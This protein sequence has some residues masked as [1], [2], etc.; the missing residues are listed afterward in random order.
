MAY[1]HVAHDCIV[2]DNCILANCVQLGGHVEIDDWVIIGGGT[3]FIN[4]K[5]LVNM[6]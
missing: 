5:K 6:L 3:L 4:L 2:G 1:A